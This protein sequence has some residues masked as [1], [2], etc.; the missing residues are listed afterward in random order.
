M[1]INIV[2]VH[3]NLGLSCIVL[4]IIQDVYLQKLQL[5][6][7]QVFDWHLNKL[8]RSLVIFLSRR[9]RMTSIILSNDIHLC[10]GI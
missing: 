6:I 3:L 9:D 10:M 4:A 7:G 1:Y 2:H 8:Q 5:I